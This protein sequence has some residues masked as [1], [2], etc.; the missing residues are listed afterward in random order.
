MK[1]IITVK[2]D[3]IDNYTAYRP[4]FNDLITPWLSEGKTADLLLDPTFATIMCRLHYL[5]VPSPIPNNR[6]NRASYWKTYYNTIAGKGA[7]DDYLLK[8]IRYIGEEIK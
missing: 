8:S 3:I 4:K 7:I 1:P 5:R 2:D 6:L